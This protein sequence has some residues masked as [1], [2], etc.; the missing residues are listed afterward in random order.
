MVRLRERLPD[1]E[2]VSAREPHSVVDFL[3]SEGFD[4]NEGIV[5]IESGSIHFGDRAMHRIA[6]LTNNKSVFNALNRWV[7]RSERRSRTLY[8]FL[9]S[10]RRMLLRIMGRKPIEQND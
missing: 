6:N 2:L 8:P 10:G 4:L 1:L 9:K 5:L 7:F 3:R